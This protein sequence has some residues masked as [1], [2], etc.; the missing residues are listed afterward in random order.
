MSIV[1]DTVLVLIASP[2]TAPFDAGLVRDVGAIARAEPTWL[3]PGEACEAMIS[4]AAPGRDDVRAMLG[5]RPID[6]AILPAAGRRKK[7]LIADMDSTIISHECIDELGAAAGVGDLVAAITA[8]AMRGELDLEASLRERL[9]LMAGLPLAAV[10][11]I[12][13]GLRYSPGARTL[14]R[15]MRRNGAHTALV[16]GG[17][18]LFTSKVAETVGFD[19]QRA[20]ELVI[21][22]GQLAGRVRE[23]ILGA[24]AKVA[25]LNE[26]CM[27]LAISAADAVAVG[28]GAND[29]GMLSAAGLGVGY[30]AK[31]V[32]R[33]ACDAEIDYADLTALLY[34]Q[35]YRK[36]EFVTS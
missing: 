14:V 32:V 2:G 13:D 3:S 8:R 5:E 25:A 24:N 20:N 21:E 34:L 15:T 12:L 4:G 29:I 17:F 16:S 11:R 36:A 7:L 23:P 1:M 18:T 9:A 6:W 10:T 22:D 35:G 27:R 30:R 26:L 31:P 19:E 33:A 28:D